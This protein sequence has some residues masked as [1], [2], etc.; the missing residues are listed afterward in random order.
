MPHV[1]DPDGRTVFYCTDPAKPAPNDPVAG[2]KEMLLTTK[3]PKLRV[4]RLHGPATRKRRK[5]YEL[6]RSDGSV[7]WVKVQAAKKAQATGRADGLISL[8]T[9][10]GECCTV[11]KRADAILLI[12]EVEGLPQY[13]TA[14]KLGVVPSAVQAR[15]NRLTRDAVFMDGVERLSAKRKQAALDLF[16]KGQKPRLDRGLGLV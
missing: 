16:A 15:M 5:F 13:E 6:I 4:V 11:F 8:P 9:C 14:A 10:A 7:W 12:D 1:T 3:L 2:L